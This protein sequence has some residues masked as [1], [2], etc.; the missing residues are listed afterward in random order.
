MIICY[1][2]VVILM[3]ETVYRSSVNN[4]HLVLPLVSC[5]FMGTYE[6]A[7]N[8]RISSEILYLCFFVIEFKMYG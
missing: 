4:C 6:N 8:I 1:E 2:N 5:W 3:N 7:S